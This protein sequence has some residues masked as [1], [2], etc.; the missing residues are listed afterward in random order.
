MDG[1]QGVAWNRV[2]DQERLS[3]SAGTWPVDYWEIV[4]SCVAFASGVLRSDGDI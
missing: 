2:Y 4:G 3:A 1:L